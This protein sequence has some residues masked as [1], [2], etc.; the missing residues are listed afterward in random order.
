[1]RGAG[2]S[3]CTCGLA[4]DF[5]GG[6]HEPTCGEIECDA[7][8]TIGQHTR[9]RCPESA[10]ARCCGATTLCYGCPLQAVAS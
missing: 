8:G 5:I 3:P 1:M 2:F 6:S 9:D 7:C 4:D 10:V